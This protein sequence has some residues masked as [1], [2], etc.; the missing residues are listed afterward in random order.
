MYG[1]CTVSYDDVCLL[2]VQVG[3]SG[4]SAIIV[5]AFKGL[6]RFYQVTLADLGIS[7]EGAVLYINIL[8]TG[9]ICF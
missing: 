4:S 6:M 3:L 5:A 9:Y 2:L 7:K 1:C 8:P